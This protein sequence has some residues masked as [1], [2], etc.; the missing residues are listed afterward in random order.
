MNE[1]AARRVV[2][3]RAIEAADSKRQV[4]SEDDRMQASREAAE[5][6]RWQARENQSDV[7]PAVFLEQ[8]AAL[9]VTRLAQEHRALTRVAS[10]RNWLLTLGVALPGLAFLAGVFVDRIA[11]PHRVDLLSPPLLLIL[12]WNVVVYAALL[13]GWLVRAL[14]RDRSRPGWLARLADLNT[15]GQPKFDQTLMLAWSR[16][17][18]EWMQMC[19]PLTAARVARILHF[20]SACFAAGA[21]VSLYLRGLGSD[22]R[23]GWESTYAWVTPERVHAVLGVLFKPATVC[24]DLP[25]FSVVDVQALRLPHRDLTGGGEQWVLLYAA[26]IFLLV[27]LPRLVLGMLARW[28]EKALAAN[29]RLDLGQ[30]YFRRLTQEVVPTASAVL[31]VYP[32]SFTLDAVRDQGLRSVA[33]MLLGGQARLALAATTAYGQDWQGSPVEPSHPGREATYGA[34]LFNLS[35]TPERE[36]HGVFLEQLVRAQVPGLCA[37]IDESAY[38]QR[39]GGH[40]DAA[41]R[42]Q[43][44]IAL[45][46]Q[47]CE[48]YHVPV[49][50]VNLV[51]PQAREAD[52]EHALPALLPDT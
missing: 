32:Y 16:F 24:F 7:S 37:M 19:A 22:Y 40:G 36:N 23:P 42:E 35:A 14:G 38:L 44:R 48:R 11:D 27:V 6:A 39:L 4:L 9:I 30:P 17:T 8:R 3:V 47:F 10:A 41:L 33:R 34:A 25:G 2:L 26:T 52:I 28:R 18:M 20:G 46:R 51:D 49:C 13:I 50:V 21:V 43:Q 12:G 1:Q 45:W 15:F 31:Q 29:F 5:L